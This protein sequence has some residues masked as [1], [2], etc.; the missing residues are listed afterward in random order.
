L[1]AWDEILVDLHAHSEVS[2]PHWFQTALITLTELAEQIVSA[3]DSRMVVPM[4]QRA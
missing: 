4:A 2:F 1:K 3:Y